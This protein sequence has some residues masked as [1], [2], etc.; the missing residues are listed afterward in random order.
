MN[1]SNEP[2]GSEPSLAHGSAP[3]SGARTAATIR[4][5][6]PRDTAAIAAFILDL[7]RYER[8]EHEC[9]IDLER[10]REHLFGP[11]PVCEALLAEIDAR[12]IGFALFYTSYSTFRTAPCVHLEDLYVDPDRRGHGTGLALLR[13]VARI[14][15][16]RGCPRLD[17]SVLDWNEPAIGFYR[18]HG[19]TVLPDWRV[20]RLDGPA[21]S[22]MGA[23][24]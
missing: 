4:A 22:A 17:W 7:A 20:C 1:E 21:L 9:T 5:A 2:N 10:L 8:R 23:A 14:A 18:R 24:Q 12:P 3:T 13:A 11:R 15:V 16:A 19:A 6:E